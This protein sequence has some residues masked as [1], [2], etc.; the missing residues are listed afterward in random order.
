MNTYEEWYGGSFAKY[1]DLPWW[2]SQLRPEDM[3][4]PWR[5]VDV[6]PYG[7]LVLETKEG[8]QFKMLNRPVVVV[9]DLIA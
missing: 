4:A 6:V 8:T 2:G 3:M 7:Y 5:V 9:G 1:R